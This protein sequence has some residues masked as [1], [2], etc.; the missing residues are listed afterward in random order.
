MNNKAK[1]T[2]LVLGGYMLGRKRKLKLA[3]T[4]AASVSG[5]ALYR[6]REQIQ[7]AL[8]KLGESSPELKDLQGK[9]TGRVVDLAGN[10]L[11]EKTDKINSTLDAAA[12]KSSD[13]AEGADDEEAAEEPE[14]GSEEKA[15]DEEPAEEKPKSGG[16][17]RAKSSSSKSG[18]SGSKS[19]SGARKTPAKSS[20]G[21]G[22]S[23]SS[24]SSRKASTS[25]SQ[26]AKK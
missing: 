23:S 6:N 3:M 5:A 8:G 18:G 9:V 25:K 7:E 12:G 15:E 11:Q 4:V 1:T 22:K 26:G 16:S 21:S 24:S 2:A 19:T 14:E 20:S 10:K 17:S 13:D